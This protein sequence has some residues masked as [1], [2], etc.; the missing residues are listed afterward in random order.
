[1]QHDSRRHIIAAAAVIVALAL[2]GCSGAETHQQASS[3]VAASSAGKSLI[4]SYHVL[5]TYMIDD[6]RFLSGTLARSE[7]Y[8]HSY[9]FSP[10]GFC[11]LSTLRVGVGQ[12][13]VEWRGYAV[14][15]D[16]LTMSPLED[17]ELR[18]RRGLPSAEPA[19]TW[20]LTV[21]GSRLILRTRVRGGATEV[22]MLSRDD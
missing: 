22:L 3:T 12:V 13:G 15:G 21:D 1:M 19:R 8:Q 18:A 10:D 4:G 14:R 7:E 16:S 11:A 17:D 20:H 2:T 5:M 9:V 6:G